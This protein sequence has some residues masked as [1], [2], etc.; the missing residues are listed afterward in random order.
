MKNRRRFLQ[1]LS[2][3]A[4]AAGF[5]TIVKAS[6]LGLN[7]AIAPSNRVAI[8]TIGVG[9]MGGDHVDSFLKVPDAQ[10][11]AVCD[12]DDSHLTA[13]KAKIDLAYGDQGTGNI[14]PNSVLIFEVELLDIPK[15]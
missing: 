7:G 2:A 14:P 4:A 15:K 5:P 12:V 10:L 3:P 1:S 6:A 13:A 11:V 8:A 9:W